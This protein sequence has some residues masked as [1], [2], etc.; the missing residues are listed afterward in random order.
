[1]TDPRLYSEDEVGEIFRAAASE[2]PSEQRPLSPAEG[3]TL[4]QLQEIG[5]EVG[6][7]PERIAD[8][9]RAL[10]LGRSALPR[11]SDLGMPVSVGRTVPLPRAPTDRE[12]DVLMSE[13]RETFH[14]RGKDGSR[15]E[16]RQWSNGNLHAFVEPT[17]E[18]YRLRLG[19]AKG[20]AVAVNRLGIFGVLMAVLL[21]VGLLASG[22][23][24]DFAAPLVLALLGGSALAYNSFRLPAWA[25]E[26]EAQMEHLAE[27]ARA[28]IGPAPA[29]EGG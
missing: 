18:G 25:L 19:T 5:G 7:A 27:R 14:A 11:R 8:A 17:E 26:R 16:L 21:L 23:A 12:W 9:A 2:R 24:A 22:G 4:A 13:L 3:F 15:G 1:M 20:D 10:E 28:L 29:P 6:V